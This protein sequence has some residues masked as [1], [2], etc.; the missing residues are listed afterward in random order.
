MTKIAEHTWTDSDIVGAIVEDGCIKLLL[1]IKNLRVDNYVFL[2]NDDI[3]A[4]AQQ[5]GILMVGGFKDD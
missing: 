4:M 5:Q 2:D 1:D 3:I